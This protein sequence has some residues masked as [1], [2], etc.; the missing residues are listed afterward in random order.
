MT[1]NGQPRWTG[2]G[3][4]FWPF[5]FKFF[6]YF[7]LKKGCN[8][9]TNHYKRTASEN[10]ILSRLLTDKITLSTCQFKVISSDTVVFSITFCEP[11]RASGKG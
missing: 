3:S 1:L 7:A 5:D 11:N 4:K 10:K 6:L 8:I 9:L 2:S